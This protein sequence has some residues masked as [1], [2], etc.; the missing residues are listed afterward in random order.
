MDVAKFLLF[1]AAFLFSA[2]LLI[3]LLVAASHDCKMSKKVKLWQKKRIYSFTN[4]TV[5]AIINTTDQILTFRGHGTIEHLADWLKLSKFEIES[6][7]TIFISE[8]IEGLGHFAFSDAP[9][10]IYFPYLTSVYIQGDLM[11]P[12]NA[13]FGN[14]NLQ[15]VFFKHRSVVHGFKN[16][17]ELDSVFY[18]GEIFIG[19]HALEDAVV[20]SETSSPIF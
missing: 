19:E 9:G 7:F 13:F 12:D 17:H 15:S 2:A 16:C 14:E 6:I 18:D 1:L 4:G 5:T 11:V 3:Y 8:E 10:E 20:W